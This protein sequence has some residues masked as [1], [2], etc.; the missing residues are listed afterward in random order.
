MKLA[1]E[2]VSTNLTVLP[3]VSA[4]HKRL[5]SML[6]IE[7]ISNEKRL[8]S[9]MSRYMDPGIADQLLAS[10]GE[11]LGGQS[12]QATILFADIR[13][14]TTITEQVGA[15]GT[16]AFLNEYF[17]LMVDCI[18][19]EGGMLDKFIGDAM[20]AGFGVPV[21]HEDDVDRGVRAAIAMMKALRTWNAQRAAE[22]KPAIDIGIGLNTDMVVSGNIGSKKRMDYTMIGDGVNLASRCESACKQ[23]GAHILASEFTVKALRGTYRMRD[24]D[25][26]VVK[27][28]TKPVAIYEILDYHTDETYPHL[29][30]AL[31]HFRDG[32]ARY[33]KREW[34]KARDEFRKVLGIN[35]TD[36]AASL[37]VDRCDLLEANPPADDWTGVWVMTDK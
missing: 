19:R 2:N 12:A 7:D 31:G 37:Y 18:Q 15:Q 36:K 25:L 23:Y 16:V 30:D 26:V 35:A 5:G 28:K 1:G 8:K 20:M 22:L 27:G 11:A 6:I 29:P 32:L 14:F 4:D 33:R 13:S 3:L 9:T 10:G 17:E 21:P 34:N 24:L